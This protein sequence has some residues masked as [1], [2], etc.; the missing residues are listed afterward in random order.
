MVFDAQC[1]SKF[2][3]KTFVTFV[4]EPYTGGEDFSDKTNRTMLTLDMSSDS[5]ADE[6]PPASL[7]L[8][9]SV[10][11]APVSLA[12]PE[13]PDLNPGLTNQP[14]EEASESAS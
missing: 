10:L 13:G 3:G 4:D 7:V 5:E 2:D 8:P 14:A 6:V 1:F 9:A 11:S 12:L